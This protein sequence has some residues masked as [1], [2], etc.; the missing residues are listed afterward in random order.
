MTSGEKYERRARWTLGISVALLAILLTGLLLALKFKRVHIG[1]DPTPGAKAYRLIY[2]RTDDPLRSRQAVLVEYGNTD[3]VIWIYRSKRYMA[4]VYSIGFGGLE[5]EASP[6][7][8]VN[9]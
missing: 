5:S 4:E 9:Q 8:K 3:C 7:I 1:W 6:A 2:W